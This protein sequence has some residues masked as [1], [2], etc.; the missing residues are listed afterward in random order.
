MKGILIWKNEK[1]LRELPT[2]TAFSQRVTQ[3]SQNSN[4]K[5]MTFW[6]EES[7]NRQ[8]VITDPRKWL[9]CPSRDP[10]LRF[11]YLMSKLLEKSVGVS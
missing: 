6:P 4:R 8:R 1:M 9:W 2:L 11:S 5:C 3:S 7:L 10:E